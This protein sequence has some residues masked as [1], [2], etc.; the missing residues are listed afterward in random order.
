MASSYSEKGLNRFNIGI[1][2][3]VEMYHSANPDDLYKNGEKKG[4]GQQISLHLVHINDHNA[5]RGSST[6]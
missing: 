5:V 3:L 1:L 2:T 4:E 6:A